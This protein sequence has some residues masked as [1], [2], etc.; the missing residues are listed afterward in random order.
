[1]TQPAPKP[2][3][4]SVS[5]AALASMQA[6]LAA[7]HAAFYLYG[8]YAART[9][10]RDSP[11]LYGTLTAAFDRHR[12]R[13]DSLVALIRS[14]GAEPV[15]SAAAYRVEDP[16]LSPGAITAAA[17]RVEQRIA[18][19]IGQMIE[20]TSGAQRRWALI[21]LEQVAVEQ[22]GLGDEPSLFPGRSG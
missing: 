18:E 7:E 6:L 9:S 14:V 19:T 13:R 17:R 5:A 8:V 21:A 1:M 3:A 15:G 20:N 11:A 16:L 2:T 10:Q 22:V 4:T 12:R